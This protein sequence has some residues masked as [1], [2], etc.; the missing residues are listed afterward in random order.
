VVWA[1]RDVTAGSAVAVK[2]FHAEVSRDPLAARRFQREV[3]LAARLDHPHIVR[4][5]HHGLAP[6]GRLFLVMERITGGSL[7]QLLASRGGHLP[8]A[9]VFRLAQQILSALELAHAAGIVHR[10]LKPANVLLQPSGAGEPTVKLC[11]FGLAKS[12]GPEADRST[13]HE[14]SSNV[15]GEL[16]GTP[17]YMSPEQVRNE[18]VDGRADLYALGVILYQCL[19]GEVPFRARSAM[20]VASRQLTEPPRRPSE[21]RPELALA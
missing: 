21:L 15:H 4:L 10:D 9:Q 17:E 14:L 7:A 2:L 6:D 11:D 19:V 16:C 5:L 8:L 1:A 20:A 13:M 18:P 3:S 12:F